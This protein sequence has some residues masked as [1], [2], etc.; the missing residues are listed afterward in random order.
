MPLGADWN[1]FVLTS[2][3]LRRATVRILAALVLLPAF[4]AAAESGAAT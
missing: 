3:T 2:G 4:P 1:L